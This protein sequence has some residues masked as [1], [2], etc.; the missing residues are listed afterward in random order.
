MKKAAILCP[1]RSVL[2]YPG[3]EAFDFVIGVNRAVGAFACDYWVFIDKYTYVLSQTSD[4]PCIG[5]PA[6]CLER[7]V[8]SQVCRERPDAK[9][10]TCMPTLHS[11]ERER[12][13]K[14]GLFSATRALVVAYNLGATDITAYGI[15]WD[16]DHPGDWDGY[17]DHR[18]VRR[19][20][21]LNDQKTR[22]GMTAGLLTERG[23][24]V[25]RCQEVA[26]VA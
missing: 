25:R 4:S 19:L 17:H 7:G 10:F 11:W 23:V 6:I 15:D 13:A 16:S 3:R 21:R 5:T 20:D 1:G 9:Q 14:S 18:Q 12:A 8:Y 2:E 24:S 26:H 22:W